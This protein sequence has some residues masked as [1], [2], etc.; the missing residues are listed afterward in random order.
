[1]SERQ[2][3]TALRVAN[4]PDDEFEEAVESPKPPTVLTAIATL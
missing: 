4:V 3:K 2:K 1:M